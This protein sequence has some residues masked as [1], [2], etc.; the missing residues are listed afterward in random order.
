VPGPR[1]IPTH[2]KVL[3]GNPGKQKLNREEPQPPQP[4][5]LLE[6]PEFLSGYAK[7]EWWRLAGEL[8]VLGLLTVLDVMPFAAYCQAYGHWR[9]A[10]EA[11]MK[12]AEKDPVTGALLVKG[13]LGDARANPLIRIANN[14]ACD[15]IRYSAEFGLTPA[16]RSRVRAGV[17]WRESGPG[18]FDGLLA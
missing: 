11:L 9:T 7:D 5:T 10:E 6:P 17:A 16:A 18:K 13:A 3:R 15:M 4:P 12:M 1:P 14:A 8:H 2:L